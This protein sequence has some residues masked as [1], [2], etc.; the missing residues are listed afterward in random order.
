[1]EVY[2]TDRRNSRRIQFKTALR[3]RVWKSGSAE[4]RL[5]SENL[6]DHGTFFASDSPMAIGTELALSESYRLQE[7]LLHSIPNA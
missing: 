2:E 1:M 6:S 5:E 4:R 7:F 3:L